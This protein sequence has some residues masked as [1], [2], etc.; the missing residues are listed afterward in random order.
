[1]FDTLKR[2]MVGSVGLFSSG[3]PACVRQHSEEDCGAACLATVCLGHGA[4]MPMGFVRHL[5]GTSRDGTTLLGLKRGAERLGFHARPAKAEASLLDELPSL[6]LPVICHWQGCHWVVLHGWQGKNLLVADPAVGLRTLSRQQFLA[7]WSNGVVLLLEPD[8]T[9]FPALEEAPSGAAASQGWGIVS[10]LLLPFRKLLLQALVLNLAIGVLALAMPLL[11]QILTDDVLIR[12]DGEMLRSLAIGILLLFVL[13][14]LLNLLQGVLV[15]HFGQKLQLQMVLHYGQH[16]LRLPL[17]YFENRRSG[18]VVSRLDDI[19]KLN[20]LIANLSL[21]LPGQL[22]IALISLAW[23]WHYSGSLTLAAL[24]GYSFVIA[25]QV[26][27]LPTLHRRTQGLLVQSAHNQ[28]FLV[29]LFSGQALLKTTQATPQ[30]WQEFQR[31]QG[32]LARKAWGVGLLDLQ[33]ST[34]TG[35]LGQTIGVL[36]LWYGSVFVLRQQL[37]IGQ[38]LAFNGM[39]A[40]V[41]AFLAAF[42]GVSQELITSRVVM[43]RLDDA[44]QH[45][46]ETDSARGSQHALIPADGD[47]VCRGLSFHHPGRMALISNLNLRIPGGLTT[48]LI[49]ESGCGKSTLTKLIAGLY[50]PDAGCIHYGDFNGRDLSLE[51]LRQQVVL[52]PQQ[53]SFLNRSIF[54]NFVFAYPQLSFADVVKLCQ[55]TLADDF[56][57]ELPDGYG[58]VL[59]EFGANLSGGQ[60]QRLALARA[61]AADPPVLLLDESTSALDPVLEARLM[62]RLLQHR[63]GKTTILVSHRPSVILRADWIVFME[64]GVVRQ[65]N[66]PRDLRDHS[67]VAPYL[68]A[69]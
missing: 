25:T 53:D 17:S 47:L 58:T 24:F 32:R 36:L 4:S 13:R 29:E 46:L 44:L 5:V 65:Q 68:Q 64:R 43:A 23:M 18:E 3:K 20:A 56:I 8:P 40:N 33:A 21:G 2:W 41:L 62:D 14:A 1:M 26:A 9:R 19:Q 31:N 10:R 27:L 60:R 39:G 11:M 30:A 38:L 63:H 15:G 66:H 34:V 35:F 42:S 45:P 69:A 50:P 52:L 51:A 22:C 57:R 7:G 61:L 55:L 28:G 67:Q 54:E 37:S 59:G 12:G 49:G 6:P 16:L 48:A